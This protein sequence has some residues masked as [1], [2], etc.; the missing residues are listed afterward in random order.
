MGQCQ[1][2]PRSPP[3][4]SVQ[5]LRNIIFADKYDDKYK[6]G[7]LYDEV[8]DNIFIGGEPTALNES[9]LQELGITHVLNAAMGTNGFSQVDTDETFYKSEII[10]YGI[11]ALDMP[12]YKISKHFKEASNFIRRAVGSKKTGQR[13]GRIFVHCVAGISRSATLVIA[14]LMTYQD[15]NLTDAVQMLRSK[16]KICPNLGF[17]QQ[18]IDYA[19]KIDRCR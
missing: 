10:F 13:G 9:I 18:L 16:R 7:N 4:V 2:S 11:P 5:D 12:S 15:T 8:F 6:L 14:Y 3:L 19:A 17:L 1:V